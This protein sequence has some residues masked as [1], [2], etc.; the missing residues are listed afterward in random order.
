MFIFLNTQPRTERLDSSG[1]GYFT[2]IVWV[3]L[4]QQNP[5]FF[6]C[7]QEIQM[8]FHDNVSLLP[9][10]LIK[11]YPAPLSVMVRPKA[12]SVF[13]TSTSL[14]SPLTWAKIKS[15]SPIC[16]P[17]SFCMSTLCELRVQNRI[18]KAEMDKRVCCFYYE[19]TRIRNKKQLMLVIW[20][21]NSPLLVFGPKNKTKKHEWIQVFIYMGLSSYHILAVAKAFL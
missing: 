19:R 8:R 11:A 2:G 3:I 4:L 16:P 5:T 12:S 14:V 10:T 18:W 6:Y 17:S 20:P 21:K 13:V 7:Q 15:S 9:F 1:S